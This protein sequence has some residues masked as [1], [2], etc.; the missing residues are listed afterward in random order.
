MTQ[1]HERAIAQAELNAAEAAYFDSDV[2]YFYNNTDKWGVEHAGRYAFHA[3]FNKGWDRRDAVGVNRVEEISRMSVALEAAQ[4]ALKEA[5]QDC[6]EA[7]DK[8]R[9]DQAVDDLPGELQIAA[10]SQDA[11]KLSEENVALR[12]LLRSVME[13]IEVVEVDDGIRSEPV[14]A[15][16]DRVNAVLNGQDGGIPS[17]GEIYAA[18]SRR[19]APEWHAEMDKLLGINDGKKTTTINVMINGIE[20][21]PVATLPAQSSQMP[22]CDTLRALRKSARLTL[23]GAGDLAGITKSY[24]WGLEKAAHQPS[25]AVAKRLADLYGVSLLDLAACQTANPGPKQ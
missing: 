15:L 17:D 14:I 8:G 9:A 11:Q 1:E 13:I 21:R 19:A 5:I 24:L 3:G 22:L 7:Y 2:D 25:L 18:A 4:N 10:I 16:L 23:Q 12:D 6:R 20:Y